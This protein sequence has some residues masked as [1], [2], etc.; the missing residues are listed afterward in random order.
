MSDA[1]RAPR[2]DPTPE[3]AGKPPRGVYYLCGDGPS[4]A[5]VR[6]SCRQG[7]SLI[8]QGARRSHVPRTRPVEGRVLCLFVPGALGL[9]GRRQRRFALLRASQGWRRDEIPIDTRRALA[10]LRESRTFIRGQNGC[11]FTRSTN[12]SPHKA[13]QGGD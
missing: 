8:L 2:T 5:A 11:L 13:Q 12:H 6:L 7:P 10:R 1:W 4:A 3:I 9:F